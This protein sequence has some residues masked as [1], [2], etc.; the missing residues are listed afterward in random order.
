M[1]EAMTAGTGNTPGRESV[2][3]GTRSFRHMSPSG[4]YS[5]PPAADVRAKQRDVNIASFSSVATPDQETEA[6]FSAGREATSARM[7]EERQRG[8]SIVPERRRSICEGIHQ[9][10]SALLS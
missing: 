6:R 1:W 10:P 5:R 3:R 4:S 9:R 8:R 7:S 2:P